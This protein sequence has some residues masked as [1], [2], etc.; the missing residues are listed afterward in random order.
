MNSSI[1][2]EDVKIMLDFVTKYLPGAGST[3]DEISVHVGRNTKATIRFSGPVGIAELDAL[4]AHLRVC[5]TY[6]K[7]GEP[8]G[9]ATLSEIREDLMRRLDEAA[10]NVGPNGD[11]VR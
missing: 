8:A 3:W 2:R 4:M 11:T 1:P 9:V 5:K 10:A 7:S 6:F